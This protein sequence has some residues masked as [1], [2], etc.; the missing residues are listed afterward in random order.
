MKTWIFIVV[1]VAGII[2]AEHHLDWSLDVWSYL[3]GGV[4]GVVGAMK[5]D[6]RG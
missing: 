1:M 3:I 2:L 4:A 5:F 6:R